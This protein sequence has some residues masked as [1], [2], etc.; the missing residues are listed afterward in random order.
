MQRKPSLPRPFFVKKSCRGIL[1]LH[2]Y[3][4]SSNDVRM[5]SRVL[6]NNNYTVSAPILTGHGTFEPLDILAASVEEWRRDVRQAFKKLAEEC[7][8][9]AVFGLSMGGILAMD[10]L[11]EQLPEIIGGGLFC[12]PLF[13]TENQVPENF[14]RYA[15][16]VYQIAGVDPVVQTEKLAR[17]KEAEGQQLKAIEAL[18]EAVAQK[19]SGLRVPVYLAQGGKDEMIDATTVY[20]TVAALPQ[21]DVS[22][23]WFAKSGHV[24]TV[25]PVHKHFEATILQFIENLPWNEEKQ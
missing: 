18:G 1:L 23:H 4:G 14:F 12:S 10:L 21:T 25:D 15:E 6:E 9:V 17:I 2:A 24:I 5:L 11:V 16:Q 7:E 22:F 3:S 20:K 19:L 13:K 8:E